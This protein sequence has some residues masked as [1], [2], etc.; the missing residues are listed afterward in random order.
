MT[1]IKKLPECQSRF[2]RSEIIENEN[3]KI[4]KLILAC[5]YRDVSPEECIECGGFKNVRLEYQVQ[6][7][8]KIT[9]GRYI[10]RKK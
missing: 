5:G 8:I 1:L 6:T 9:K 2:G 7:F 3:K 10:H 4:A